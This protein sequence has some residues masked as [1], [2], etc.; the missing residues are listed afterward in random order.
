VLVEHGASIDKAGTD[1]MTPLYIAAQAGY[2]DIV[3]M[4][5]D[6]GAAIDKSTEDG[7]SPLFVAVEE[8]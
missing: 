2:L 3:K 8:E 6:Y 5:L 7:E 1:G 4:L